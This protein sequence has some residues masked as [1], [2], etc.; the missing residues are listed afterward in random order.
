VNE[1]GQIVSGFVT[2]LSNGGGLHFLHQL[3]AEYFAARWLF[4]TMTRL[5]GRDGQNMQV[6]MKKMH[7][8]VENAEK[9]GK[10]QQN[11]QYI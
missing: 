3:F 7:I 9:M 5:K 8:C 1:P 2:E 11:M 4:E 10:M 6:N